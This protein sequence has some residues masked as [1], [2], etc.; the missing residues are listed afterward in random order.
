MVPS[1]RHRDHGDLVAGFDLEAVELRAQELEAVAGVAR[2]DGEIGSLGRHYA[3]RGA[4]KQARDQGL[5]FHGIPPKGLVDREADE[6]RTAPVASAGTRSPP[7]K[8]P[9]PNLSSDPEK[10]FKAL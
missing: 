7:S 6:W 3:E 9:D 4:G 1:E 5:Q 2:N 8:R 10:T